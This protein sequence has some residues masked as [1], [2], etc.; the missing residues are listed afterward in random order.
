MACELRPKAE[1]GIWLV[2]EDG[3]REW[4]KWDTWRAC[5]GREDSLSEG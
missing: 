2:E 5:G 4:Q 1:L 3:D